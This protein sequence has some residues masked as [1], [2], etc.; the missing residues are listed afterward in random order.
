ML[1]SNWTP[2]MIAVSAGKTDIVKY[3]I[4]KGAQVNAVNNNGQCPLH[5][6]A[7]KDRFEA[8]KLICH[9]VYHFVIP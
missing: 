1:Q 9:S 8:S 4:A 6:A 3:L 7:S 2:L 5:Y